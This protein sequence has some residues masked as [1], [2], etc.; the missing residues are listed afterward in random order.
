MQAVI[1]FWESDPVL[2]GALGGEAHIYRHGEHNEYL[3]PAVYW[4]IFSD[5]T[6][7]NTNPIQGQADIYAPSLETAVTIEARLRELHYD[8]PREVSGLWMLAQITDARD[9]SEGIRSDRGIIGVHRS[10]DF[11]LEV[12]RELTV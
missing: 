6:E 8:N 10:I 7:E 2:I 1:D 9:H 11:R 5:L 4:M 3:N 12:A